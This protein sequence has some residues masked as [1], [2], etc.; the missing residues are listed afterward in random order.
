[1][2]ASHI[3]LAVALLLVFAPLGLIG[4]DLGL[5]VGHTLVCVP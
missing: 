1:L 2:T 5:I 4:T 3:P